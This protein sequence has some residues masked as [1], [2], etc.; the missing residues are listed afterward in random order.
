VSSGATVTFT[1]NATARNLAVGTYGPTTIT[2][3]NSDTGYGTQTR[4]A[5][6]TVYPP[7]I[8]VGPTTGIMASGTQGGPF[9][10]SSFRYSLSTTLGSLNYSIVTPSWL[11]ASPESGT[12]TTTP[13]T[14][15][16]T[17]NASARSLQPDTYVNSI[18]FYNT[19]NNQGNTTRVATLVVSPKQ[20]TVTVRASPAG[21]GTVS[22]GG[23]FVEGSSVAV[24]ATANPG[25]TFVQW[26]DKGKVVSTSPTYT[27][28]LPSANV[29]LVADFL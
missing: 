8:Q 17:I 5:T 9:S 6:L 15:D 2:F 19:T 10:P 16:F 22:G 11:T 24:M 7:A 27:F 3:A 29:T 18:S 4:M 25:H 14:V 23:T 20:Y 21:D 12:V 13:K 26:T 1:V 28:T